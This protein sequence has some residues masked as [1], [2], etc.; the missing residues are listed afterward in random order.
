MLH[1]NVFLNHTGAIC[2]PSWTNCRKLPFS[3]IHSVF[4]SAHRLHLVFFDKEILL[5][6][7]G[8]TPTVRKWIVVIQKNL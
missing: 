5:S 6:S 4:S 8:E 1:P 3:V 7:C 2:E